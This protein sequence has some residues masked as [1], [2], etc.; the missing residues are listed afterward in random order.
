MMLVVVSGIGRLTSLRLLPL[1]KLRILPL[2]CVIQSL[3]NFV[4]DGIQRGRQVIGFD[5]A[6]QGEEDWRAFERGCLFSLF[7]TIVAKYRQIEAFFQYSGSC[8]AG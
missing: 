5:V 2:L 3:N 6:S 8:T 7:S 1:E 4:R